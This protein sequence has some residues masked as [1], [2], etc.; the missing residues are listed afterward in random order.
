MKVMGHYEIFIR[1]LFALK[2]IAAGSTG[3]THSLS[4]MILININLY[5]DVIY[6]G[7]FATLLILL[8]AYFYNLYDLKSTGRYNW[9][10]MLITLLILGYFI[11]KPSIIQ[12]L[13]YFSLISLFWNIIYSKK[14][15]IKIL[16]YIGLFM[17]IVMPL[18]S[19]YAIYNFG[20]YSIWIAIPLV[21]NLFINEEFT[22]SLK[23]DHLTTRQQFN[24]QS[25]N[26]HIK[27]VLLMSL[28][29]FAGR[30]LYKGVYSSYSDAGS[31]IYKTYKIN[32]IKT[33]YIF[34]TRGRATIINDLLDGI[35]PFIKAGDNLIAYESIPMIYYLTNTIPYLHDSWLVGLGS[36][37]FKRKIDRVYKEN[38]PLPLV[39]RQKFDTIGASF[40]IPNDEYISDNRT[41]TKFVSQEQTRMFNQFLLE[42][43]YKIIWQNSHFVLY[44]PQEKQ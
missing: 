5:A 8:L 2:E 19:D 12:V 21:I 37:S 33:K 22:I 38:R 35:K 6:I 4:S 25:D 23:I 9:L 36:A 28:V 34:T 1:N 3:N 30:V 43:N 44:A 31:R 40:G 16:S 14:I 41:S 39:I 42:N 18:G 11:S 17:L 15:N 24:F 7:L 26:Y 13:Y 29:I 20:N 32:S 10:M 27:L